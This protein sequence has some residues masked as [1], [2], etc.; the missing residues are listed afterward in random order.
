MEVDEEGNPTKDKMVIHCANFQSKL[1]IVGDKGKG[2][3]GE[4]D[5][6]LRDYSEKEFKII[7]LPLKKCIDEEAFMEIGLRALPSKAKSGRNSTAFD[8]E[9]TATGK[10]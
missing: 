1:T 10:D 5:L 7:K 2:V 4:A 6:N 3:L 9:S 8:K